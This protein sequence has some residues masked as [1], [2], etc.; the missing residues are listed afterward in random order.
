MAL[1]VSSGEECAVSLWRQQPSDAKSSYIRE[2]WVSAP[3]RLED[4]T[5][6]GG[7]YDGLQENLIIL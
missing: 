1:L 3:F 4:D 5:P 7:K 2:N 6:Q